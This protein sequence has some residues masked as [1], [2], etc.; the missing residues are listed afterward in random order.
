MVF[1]TEVDHPVRLFGCQIDKRKQLM[2]Y[3]NLEYDTILR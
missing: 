2:G 3:C 1:E